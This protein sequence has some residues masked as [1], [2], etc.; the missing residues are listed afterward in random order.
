MCIRDSTDTTPSVIET[1]KAPEPTTVKPVTGDKEWITVDNSNNM[2][3]YASADNITVVNV[4][5]P[6]CLLYTSR[7]V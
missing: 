5:H 4:Q 3:S 6:G 1:T 7:C 2:Y